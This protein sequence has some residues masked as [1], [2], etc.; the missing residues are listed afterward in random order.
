[1]A[2]TDVAYLEELTVHLRLT[3][4]A[5][6]EI[7]AV[8]EEAQDH[9][10]ASGQTPEDAFGPPDS[11][12]KALA[13]SRGKASTGKLPLS[14]GDLVAGAA[15]LAGWA[16]FVYSAVALASS[17]EVELLPGHIASWVILIAGFIW[18]VWPVVQAY[19][20][21][22]SGLLQAS[23]TVTLVLAVSV[24][25]A[26]TWHEPILAT[27]PAIPILVVS[28]AI[29]GACWIRA[30]RVRDPIRRPTGNDAQTH[31]LD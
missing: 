17:A 26:A 11:Y 14:P 15:Q 10:E 9:L 22:R 2:R 1:M 24:V 6:E 13:I 25:P 29:I 31:S 12:A 30:W 16:G 27:V 8:I 7:G 3:G 19:M 23:M 20:A 4:M 5:G 28:I 21:R 18:P